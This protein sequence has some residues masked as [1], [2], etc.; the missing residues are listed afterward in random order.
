MEATSS[1]KHNLIVGPDEKQVVRQQTISPF[2]YVSASASVSKCVSLCVCVCVCACVRARVR[3]CAQ[4]AVV[5]VFGSKF[6][7]DAPYPT[8]KVPWR[9]S[10]GRSL[11][12]FGLRLSEVA[13]CPTQF[14]RLRVALACLFF[15]FCL[16]FFGLKS[17]G[18]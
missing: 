8:P 3:A 6:C 5:L 13:V 16:L 11:A 10:P 18:P 7:E 12:T 17:D 2:T 9:N 15:R 4:W 1:G 14:E